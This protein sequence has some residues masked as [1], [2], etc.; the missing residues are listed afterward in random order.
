M[1][2]LDLFSGIGGLCVEEVRLVVEGHLIIYGFDTIRQ[3][4]VGIKKGW[5]YWSLIF[6]ENIIED[7][8]K[9]RGYVNEGLKQRADAKI[10]VRQPLQSLTIRYGGN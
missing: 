9:V 2:H 3:K 8:Q 10:K 5:P 7:M 1:V 6:T 4:G